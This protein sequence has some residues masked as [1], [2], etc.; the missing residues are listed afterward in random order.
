MNM[1]IINNGEYKMR[2]WHSLKDLL[3]EFLR[4]DSRIVELDPVKEGYASSESMNQSIKRAIVRHG[5]KSSMKSSYRRDKVYLIKIGGN[6]C[7]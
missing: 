2:P 5:L 4:M 7:D 1:K 3:R 6:E